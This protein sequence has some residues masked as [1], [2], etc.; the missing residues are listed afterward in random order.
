LL[1]ATATAF[2]ALSAPFSAQST[3]VGNFPTCNVDGTV[4]PFGGLDDGA[5]VFF[6]DFCNKTLYRFSDS[7]LTN[8]GDAT[9]PSAQRANGLDSG[10]AL[11][12]GS[13][14]GIV[15]LAR[16]SGVPAGL[17]AFDPRTLALTPPAPRVPASSFG[18]GTPK[19][20][21]ADPQSSDLYVSS[22]NGVYRVQNPLS[23]SPTVTQ[24]A[25]GEFDG[26]A[27]SNSGSALYVAA[28]R[29][30]AGHVFAFGRDGTMVADI[31][32]GGGPD[33]LA[34]A[35]AG[36]VVG[37]IDVSNNLFVNNNDGTVERVDVNH[38]NSV[39]VVASGGE[40]GD[41]AFVDSKGGLDVSQ[42][43]SY[44]RLTRTAG[45]SVFGTR[46]RNTSRPVISGTPMVGN[47]LMC[48]T[49]AWTGAVA[50]YS[51]RWDRDG[52]PIAGA[53]SA[54]SAG[55]T[56]VAADKGHTF[57]CAVTASN[58]AGSA[59]ATS[60]P[61]TV[62]GPLACTLAAHVSTTRRAV[63]HRPTKVTK[64]I[65]LT[66]R[67]DQ[68][69]RGSITGTIRKGPRTKAH[70]RGKV[71]AVRFPQVSVTISPLHATIVTVQM[72]PA[73]LKVLR[74]AKHA[75][76]SFSLRVTNPNGTATA[77]VTVKLR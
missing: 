42:A 31:S 56:V 24:F 49:G 6:T 25:R 74:G 50:A 66:V 43:S 20:V 57:T 18:T 51:Y 30:M 12:Q 41:L 73:T 3:L 10:L 36:Q 63:K 54:G 70:P 76:A 1:A 62:P 34:V 4:G 13:Y 67:C 58:S 53:G 38:G 55:Y 14:F 52:T 37:G 64:A 23:G 61:V 45:P 32:V 28:R 44:V 2:T 59:T 22:N 47:A 72:R 16:S 75:T 15:Q 65:K 35:P 7:V 8:A 68:A 26:I 69:A 21:A 17:Y 71:L 39:S 33:G 60:D 19:G 77:G 11:S 29:S 46:P 5:N 48:S 27:F 9:S 40:R